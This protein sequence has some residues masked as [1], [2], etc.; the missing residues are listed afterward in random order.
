LNSTLRDL[1]YSIKALRRTPLITALAIV[2]LALGIG[3]NTAL[4]SVINAVLLRPLTYPHPERIVEVMRQFPNETIWATTATKFAFWRTENH[5]FEA[6]AAHSFVPV[7]LN[8]VG[9]GE[10]QRLAALI[11]TADYFRVLGI[12]PA[13]GRSYTAAEDKPGSGKFAVLSFPLWQK[14]FHGDREVLGKTLSLSDES[15][16]VIG[17][18]PR[19]FESP[20]QADL[21]VPMQLKI[22]PSDISNNYPVIARLKQGVTLAMARADM[23][24]VAEHFHKAYGSDKMSDH[25]S[26][27]LSS[28]RDFLTDS[29]KRPLWILLATVGLVLLIACANVA[30]LLLARS[31]SRQ[32]EMAIRVAIGAS[33]SQLIKQLLAESLVLAFAG[34]IAGCLL[35]S[36]F[37]PL[38]LRLAPPDIPR[39]AG[40]AIDVQVLVYALLVAITTGILFGLFPAI[41]SARLGIANP[42]REGGT[43]IT[44]NVASSRV[45]QTL[46]VAEIAITLLLLIG[47]SLLIDTLK[48]L[49]SVR[50]GF[51]AH[52]VLTMQMSL[53]DKYTDGAALAKLNARV[54][55]RLEAS[56]GVTSVATAG[57]LPLT[58]F[59][60]LPF[61]I[62]GRPTKPDDMP[63][64]NYRLVSPKYF[65]TLRIPVKSGREFDERDAADSAPVIVISNA[66][67]K[68]YFP[69]E[70]PIGQQILVGRAMGPIFADKPRRIIG[71]VGDIRDKGLDQPPTPEFFEPEAQVPPALLHLF[72]ET[73]PLNWIV[74]T[75]R[76]PM[77]I[78]EQ[79]RREA[80]TVAGDLPMA[81]PR[82][83]ERIVSDS[84]SRERFV[85]GLLS[86]FAGLALLLGT[87]GLYGVISYSVAQRTREL[88]IRSAL[89]AR[90]RNLLSLVVGEGM[91]LAVAGLLLGLLCAFALTRYL[92]SLL[93]GISPSDPVVLTAV[94]ALM[95]A[96]TLAACFFPAYR[97]SRIDPL[98][99]LHEE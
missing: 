5:S 26:I 55:A 97:A 38:L 12:Q 37:L 14:L 45:R 49:Q 69:R 2:T 60:D 58:P 34:A 10:P 48:N 75:A 8:L 72:F 81:D 86:L 6:M 71:V 99:A 82:P 95:G 57:F 13:I 68:R 16:Q 21:W 3:A 22:D 11:T 96:V 84:L 31:A 74:R 27:A 36:A 73:L 63:D 20:Q 17:V 85:M 47:A 51:D 80:L 18:M 42:L 70:N 30:N 56:P 52:G 87:V 77:A 90:R 64:E 43:R 61:E 98:V 88:G 59:A 29:T 54:A 62:V 78:A 15:Y 92:Q 44:T 4:F 89:G 35:A 7:G 32:R 1:R 24:I 25:E 53:S 40:A 66:L 94:T 83:L 41:Q 46:V 65:A 50:A 93:Y 76:D 9:R 67:A 39:L 23:K 79:I 33:S 19:G 28:F 91:R